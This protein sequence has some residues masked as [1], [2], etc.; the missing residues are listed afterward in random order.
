[1][2]DLNKKR[3]KESNIMKFNYLYFTQN[4]KQNELID[5]LE[6]FL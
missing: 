4:H 3:K 2:F 6:I 5:S 1:M